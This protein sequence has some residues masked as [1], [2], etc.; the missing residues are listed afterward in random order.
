MIQINLI[1]YKLLLTSTID[2]LNNNFDHKNKVGKLRFN[3]TNDLIN[4]IKSNTISEED[5]K[6][7]K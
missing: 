7:K 4:S 3:D 2:L 5:A 6:K 1:K